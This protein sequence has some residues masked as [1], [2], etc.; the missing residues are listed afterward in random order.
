M[1]L[2]AKSGLFPRTP[3][4]APALTLEMKKVFGELAWKGWLYAGVGDG[5]LGS[6]GKGGSGSEG[7]KTE[8]DSA[9]GKG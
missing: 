6:E 9:L 2:S 5:S 1:I 4:P 3:A 8:N 7:E